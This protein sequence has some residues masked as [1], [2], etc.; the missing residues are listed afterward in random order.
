MERVA[1]MKFFTKL[2]CVCLV[3]GVL[4]VLVPQVRGQQAGFADGRYPKNQWVSLF[5]GKD[6]TGWH[7]DNPHTTVKAKTPEERQ[8]FRAEHREAMQNKMGM[9]RQ[10][11]QDG[12]CPM[13]KDD[14]MALAEAASTLPLPAI[15][16]EGP[17]LRLVADADG[18][19]VL[20]P[21]LHEDDIDVADALC[22]R[23]GARRGGGREAAGG[24]HCVSL[25]T[26]LTPPPSLRSGTPSIRAAART[27]GELSVMPA[28]PACRRGR[29]G[30]ARGRRRWPPCA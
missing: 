2:V 12:Q 15:L 21:G 25:E 5:N 29:G 24:V 4:A 13:A 16:A 7:G 18:V 17:G 9:M 1:T 23:G 10:R 14:A 8:K 11:M 19:I 26:P 20:P 27:E 30:A 6:L 28:V 22:A 3:C